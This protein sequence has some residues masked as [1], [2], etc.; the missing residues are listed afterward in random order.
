MDDNK[1]IEMLF[2]RAEDALEEIHEKYA[3]LY[4]SI[5]Q[6]TLSNPADTDECANDVLIAIWNSIPPN[7]PKNLSAYISKIARRVG[8][9]KLR[10]NTRNKRNTDYL[11]MLSELSDCLPAEPYLDNSSVQNERLRS[12]LSDF[13]RHLEPTTQILFI[14]R[15]VCFESVA[16]LVERFQLSENL[17]SVKLYRARKK[18]KKL[19]EKEGICV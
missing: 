16:S 19:L 11:V 7:R 6:K 4:R 13:I 2:D 17:I 10:Y 12:L 15:Y 3:P 9:D 8:I 18:L 5:L 1:I 14:R